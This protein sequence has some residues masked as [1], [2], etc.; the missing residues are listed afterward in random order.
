MQN[1]PWKT[2]EPPK[3]GTHII[4]VGRIIVEDDLGCSVQPYLGEIF[5]KESPSF[6]GYMYQSE[7]W[8]LSVTCSPDET[9]VVDWWI[10]SPKSIPVAGGIEHRPA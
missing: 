4:A 10:E 8:P 2:T 9:L 6:T 7:S 1:I 3:D 5:W